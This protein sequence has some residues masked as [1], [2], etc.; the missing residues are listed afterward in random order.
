MCQ[1]HHE[2]SRRD[3]LRA[4]A[5]CSAYIALTLAG[6]ST[7]TRKAFAAGPAGEIIAQEKFA[8]VE[9][10]A[11]GIYAVISTPQGGQFTTVSNGGI[12]VGKDGV[13]AIEGF[14]NPAGAQWLR[15]VSEKVAGRAPTHVVLTHFHNDHIAGTAGYAAAGARPKLFATETVRARLKPDVAQQ[16]DATVIKDDAPTEL[17]FGGRAIR[18]VPRKGHTPSDLSIELADPKLTWCGDLFWNGMFPNYIDALPA[19]LTANCRDLLGDP[20]T[21]YVPGHGGIAQIGTTDT[22][23]YIALLEDIEAA[24]RKAHAAGTPAAEAAKAYTAPAALGTWES[25]APSMTQSVFTAWEKE[26]TKA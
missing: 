7:A 15:G 12:I 1:H 3:F 20:K 23:N 24:A 8:R 4:T 14:M 26:L 18:F 25:L 21:T 2:P 6:V 16:V 10:L 19:V 22:T 17:D 5:S 13:L 9:K 11:D